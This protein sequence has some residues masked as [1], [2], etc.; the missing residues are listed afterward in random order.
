MSEH[1]RHDSIAPSPEELSEQFDT[2]GE[3]ALVNSSSPRRIAPMTQEA[4]QR[5]Q[6]R[7]SS[8]V[9]TAGFQLKLAAVLRQMEQAAATDE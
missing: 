5:L 3:P 2:A 8:H 4:R 9:Q 6:E 1:Q 7:T